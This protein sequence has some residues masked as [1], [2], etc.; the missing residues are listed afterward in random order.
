MTGPDLGALGL[1]DAAARQWWEADMQRHLRRPIPPPLGF[2]RAR[3]KGEIH[4]RREHSHRSSLRR[5]RYWAC[6]HTSSWSTSRT[7][8]SAVCPMRCR[9]GPWYVGSVSVAGVLWARDQEQ[10]KEHGRRRVPDIETEWM[11]T[12]PSYMLGLCLV[13]HHYTVLCLSVSLPCPCPLPP[14]PTVPRSPDVKFAY[15]T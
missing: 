3:R 12:L 9:G 7:L 11:W 5:R 1:R 2:R 14:S 15:A 8:L 4:C 13:S 10:M 6:Q